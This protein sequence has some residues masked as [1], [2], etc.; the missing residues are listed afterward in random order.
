[1]GREPVNFVFA[2]D[3]V[4]IDDD[5]ED[6]AFALDQRCIDSGCLFYRFRQTGGLGRVVSLHAIGDRN[7]HRV[8][9]SV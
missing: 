4:A 2:E 6:A 7:L 1:V 8:F 5:I 9:S 3:R